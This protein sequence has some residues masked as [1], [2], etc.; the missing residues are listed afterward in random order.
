MNFLKR[1]K[2]NI[3]LLKSFWKLK[4]FREYAL[5]MA[6]ELIKILVIVTVVIVSIV[7][8]FKHLGG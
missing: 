3:A 5:G 6:I 1:I 4:D 8:I 2:R 7:G